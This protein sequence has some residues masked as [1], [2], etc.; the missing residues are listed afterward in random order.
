[1]SSEIEGKR[2]ECNIYVMENFNRTI[3][4]G[5]VLGEKFELSVVAFSGKSFFSGSF[6]FANDNCFEKCRRIYSDLKKRRGKNY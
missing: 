1:M 5:K 6:L 2:A 3:A 4:N